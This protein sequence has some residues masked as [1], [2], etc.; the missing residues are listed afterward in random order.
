[1]QRNPEE[2][3]WT[4][5][6]RALGSNQRQPEAAEPETAVVEQAAEEPVETDA[7]RVSAPAATAPPPPPPPAP[8]A[9]ARPVLP[10]SRTLVPDDAE[11][12]IGQGTIVEGSFRSDHSIRIVGSVKGDVESKRSIF[13]DSAATLEEARVSAESI[14]VA[15]SVTGELSCSG[16]VLITA[17]GHVVGQISA[18]SLVMEEGAFFEGQLKMLTRATPG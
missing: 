17:S 3:E 11:S 8:V 1:M 5:F 9:P 13:I 10:I 16:K 14:T 2:S 6:S 7:T 4:R 12:V 15:G 18:G